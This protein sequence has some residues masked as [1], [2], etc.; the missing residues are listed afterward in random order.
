MMFQSFW[1]KISSKDFLK[2][3]LPIIHE[4]IDISIVGQFRN[5]QSNNIDQFYIRTT[6]L[7]IPGTINDN[8]TI[9]FELEPLRTPIPSYY[10]THFDSRYILEVN[11]F[12]RTPANL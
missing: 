4:G 3:R 5:V 7:S 6:N 12:T 11:G 1:M 8:S 10:G 9:H 2:L